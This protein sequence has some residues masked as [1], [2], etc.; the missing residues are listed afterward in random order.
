MATCMANQEARARSRR[1]LVHCCMSGASTSKRPAGMVLRDRHRDPHILRCPFALVSF[2]TGADTGGLHAPP[3]KNLVFWD[4]DHFVCDVSQWAQDFVICRAAHVVIRDTK[5]PGKASCTIAHRGAVSTSH[6]DII[7]G[8]GS[9]P[10]RRAQLRRTAWTQSLPPEFLDW[11][12]A[13]HHG[14]RA[15]LWCSEEEQHARDLWSAME[16]HRTIATPCRVL[17]H[18][19][20]T[21]PRNAHNTAPLDIFQGHTLVL[22]EAPHPGHRILHAS[23]RGPSAC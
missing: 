11:H 1:H 12:I 22:A 5:C 7:S 17:P 16:R 18:T 15:V 10:I 19:H 6:L 13:V 23:S 8:S 4:E 20:L 2:V 9:S 3:A 14:K 21:H